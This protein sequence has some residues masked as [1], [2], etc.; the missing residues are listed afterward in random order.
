MALQG[1]KTSLLEIQRTMQS[2]FMTLTIG[3]LALVLAVVQTIVVTWSADVTVRWVSLAV[4]VIVGVLL[5]L[6]ACTTL[7]TGRGAKIRTMDQR[8]DSADDAIN[9][10]K[11][12]KI[13]AEEDLLPIVEASAKKGEITQERYEV[14]RK[15]IEDT[16]SYFDRQIQEKEK[17]LKGL[18]E[19]KKRLETDC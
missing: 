3:I 16:V 11:V 17:E 18:E 6:Y 13:I 5:A 1:A 15:R 8:I 4:V 2:Q 9:E 10:Y 14:I 7:K 12:L 19:D